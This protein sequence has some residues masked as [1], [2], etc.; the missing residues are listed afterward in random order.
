MKNTKKIKRETINANKSHI[1]DAVNN[2]NEGESIWIRK[3]TPKET[4]RFMGVEERFV[5]RMTNP[6]AELEKLGYNRATI[7][8]LLTVN[9]R[10]QKVSNQDLCHMAGN[11]IVVDLL[12]H[13]FMSMFFGNVASDVAK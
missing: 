2:I 12:H 1:L 6:V 11:S 4:L 8:A 7:D 9:G 10:R 3:T 5:D 13:V